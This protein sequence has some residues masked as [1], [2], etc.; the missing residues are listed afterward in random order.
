MLAAMMC[1]VI[2]LLIIGASVLSLGLHGRRFSVRT[3]SDIVA[4][5]AADAGLTK[6]IFEMN[7]KLKVIPWDDSQ[8][9]EVIN[10]T[11]PNTDATYSYVVTGDNT[12]GYNVVSIG[13]SGQAARKVSAN[14]GRKELFDHAVLT[15]GLL[16]LK[17]GTTVDGYNSLDPFDTDV[18][19]KI[20]STS[21]LD[22]QIILQPGVT[23]NGD[24]LVGV[25]GDPATIIND[26][27]ATTGDRSAMMVEPPLDD[28]ITPVLPDMGTDI[29][30]KGDTLTI[31]PADS[32]IYTS[33]EVAQKSE[34]TGEEEV[35]T[36]GVVV[37][38]GGETVLHVTG[39]I[40]LKAL[41]K[42]N[43]MDG[44]SLILYVDGDIACGAGS[45]IGYQ[46]A[47]E[48]PQH[49][50]IYSTNTG[51]YEQTF[52]IMAGSH[53]SGVIYAPYTD[54]SIYAEG[55]VY[56]SFITNSFDFKALGNLYYDDALRD[57]TMLN[58]RFIVDRWLEE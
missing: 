28:V 10:E 11:L 26:Q 35:I 18:D 13:S 8:L 45:D 41:C 19:L 2:I 50:Q 16:S 27:G 12:L 21:V 54:V 51:D 49:L 37:V 14:L 55:D 4:R 31:G 29:Y 6:A 57:I 1:A 17:P 39:D 9:P 48:Q 30:V 38:D 7:E 24:I 3:S 52:D 58:S 42:I 32:G 46:G 5:C 36:P 33:I 20:A 44:S 43:I 23:I 25:G 22:D 47:P 15:K 53:F 40:W 34:G 56:G